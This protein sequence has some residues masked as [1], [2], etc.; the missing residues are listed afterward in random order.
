MFT[1]IFSLPYE[2]G[3]AL[4]HFYKTAISLNWYKLYIR[5]FTEIFPLHIYIIL[6]YWPLIQHFL[7]RNI[8]P[9]TPTDSGRNHIRPGLEQRRGE[10]DK[11]KITTKRWQKKWEEEKEKIEKKHGNLKSWFSS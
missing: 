7:T 11:K 10:K 1:G 4:Q 2:N 8:I 9:F 6:E 5:V 3:N